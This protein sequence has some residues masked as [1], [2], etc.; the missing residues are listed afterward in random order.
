MNSD[1]S[2]QCGV[3]V[4]LLWITLLCVGAVACNEQTAEQS[5]KKQHTTGGNSPTDSFFSFEEQGLGATATS[6]VSIRLP[7]DRSTFIPG[8]DILLADGGTAC[9][10]CH[11][12]TVEE[13]LE[14]PLTRVAFEV[15]EEGCLECHSADYVS[16]QP[17]LASAAWAKVVTKMVDKFDPASVNDYL[18]PTHQGAMVQYLSTVYGP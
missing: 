10:T 7:P 17:P 4:K 3:V 15:T 5:T 1:M 2:I 6:V 12:G 13:A 9:M 8:P 18:N 16:S 14:D 11:N